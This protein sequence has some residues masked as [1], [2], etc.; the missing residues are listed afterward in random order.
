MISKYLI[1]IVLW[2]WPWP[3]WL[4]CNGDGKLPS[5]SAKSSRK[6]ASKTCHGLLMNGGNCGKPG[7]GL[8]CSRS[9]LTCCRS[10]LTTFDSFLITIFSE[11]TWISSSSSTTSC[12]QEQHRRSQ[13]CFKKTEKPL[14]R[15]T[16]ASTCLF[17]AAAASV[18]LQWYQLIL[19]DNMCDTLCL[20]TYIGYYRLL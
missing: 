1:K 19:H 20:S 11:T 9:R 6:T 15:N 14:Q 18:A 8:T 10:R 16:F 7:S 12:M 17:L 2:L 4:S 5:A 13:K 3:I